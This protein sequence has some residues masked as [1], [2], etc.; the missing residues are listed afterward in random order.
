MT[1]EQRRTVIWTPLATWAGL[2]ALAATT[3]GY[4]YLPHAPAKAEASVAI[5]LAKALLVAWIFMQLRA[6]AGIVRV[7]AVAGVA[8]ASFL[9]ILAFADVMTR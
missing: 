3:L 2:I 7:A 9:Y 5:A 4:A 6:A 1:R 8:W